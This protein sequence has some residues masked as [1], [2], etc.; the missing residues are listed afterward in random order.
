MYEC[1]VLSNSQQISNDLIFVISDSLIGHVF[2]FTGGIVV[3]CPKLC[4]SEMIEIIIQAPP[5]RSTAELALLI[6]IADYTPSTTIHQPASVP[7]S[8]A[9]KGCYICSHLP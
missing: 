6:Q 7:T 8:V 4:K 3:L 2:Y 5:L 9:A 1:I